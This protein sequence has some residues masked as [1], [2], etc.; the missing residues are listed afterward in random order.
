MKKSEH[1]NYIVYNKKTNGGSLMKDYTGKTIFVGMD[2]HKKTYSVTAIC[3]GCII[4][5]DTLKADPEGLISYLKKR[6]GS[7]EIKTAYEA[8]FCGFHLHRTLE[9]AEIKNIVVHAAGIETSNSRVK[10]DKR[11]SLKI[12]AHLSE[13]KLRC[14]YIPTVEREDSRTVTRLRDTFCRERSRIGNQIKSLLFLHGLI[15]ADNKKK[16]SPVWIK[17]LAKFEMTAGVRFSI[18]MFA[19][20]WLEFDA[21][22]KEIDIEIKKQ[23]IKDSAIDAVYQSVSGIGCT[24]ARVLANELGD[25]MQFKNE[26]QLFS[27]IGFT[28]SEHSSGEHTRQGHITKQGKPI[29]RKILVQ[30]AWVAIRHDKELQL[31]Y[32]RIAEKSGAKRAIV[33][34]AR[35]LIGRTRA[36]FRT[37]VFYE[38][39]KV[40]RPTLKFKKM[41]Q[42]TKKNSQKLVT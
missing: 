10:T 36:C 13:G 29:V 22:V 30:A 18:E 24:S 16:V 19:K 17:S 34:I 33:A 31:I 7:G 21:K 28:P 9:A 39:K 26:R 3:D 12:V 5:R 41:P 6:F 25:L 11:D 37:G 42:T 8:G 2:V 38:A 27:Y 14:V 1:S 20:T 23:A 32:E 4:K 15:P 40:E 35:R